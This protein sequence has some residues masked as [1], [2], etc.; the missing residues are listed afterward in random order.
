MEQDIENLMVKLDDEK[1]ESEYL[2]EV[3]K[4]LEVDYANLKN[5]KKQQGIIKNPLQNKAFLL[6]KQIE[7]ETAQYDALK[8]EN[9]DTRN[10]INELRLENSACKK[11]LAHLKALIQT[12]S[13]KAIKVNDLSKAEKLVFM[14]S[15]NRISAARSRSVLSKVD[16]NEKIR[17]ISVI[18]NQK[19]QISINS[20]QNIRLEEL[21]NNLKGCNV[22]KIQTELKSRWG[23][24]LNKSKLELENYQ[25]YIESIKTGFEEIGL[26]V[27]VTSIE[28][29][30]TSFIK[31]NEQNHSLYQYLSLLNSDID[32]V[33]DVIRGNKEKIEILRSFEFK[34]EKHQEYL[35]NLIK[36]IEEIEK[37]I[38]HSNSKTKKLNEKTGSA[39]K[40]I[41]QISEKIG[42]IIKSKEKFEIINENSIEE[43]DKIIKT[44]DDGI[45]KIKAVFKMKSNKDEGKNDKNEKKSNKDERKSIEKEIPL[46]L[47]FLLEQKDVYDDPDLEEMK[48]PMQD[49]DF[50][51]KAHKILMNTKDW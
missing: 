44:T 43:F 4:N 31:A 51:V 8:N 33:E 35:L 7:Y 47:G 10:R 14:T 5:S 34:E 29:I 20:K 3:I 6:E 17:E 18:L 27:G 46:K 24:I 42:S 50:S 32:D 40:I 30:V 23:K 13:S 1:R 9:F 2:D 37:K 12:S 41:T 36:K 21:L 15:Q 16:Y 45:E 11:S 48:T 39:F 22:F 19:S 26:A 25:K 38:L 49:H 28:D